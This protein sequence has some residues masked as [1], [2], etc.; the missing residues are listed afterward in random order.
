MS[1]ILAIP[2]VV[3]ALALVGCLGLLAA[4]VPYQF[5]L[6]IIVVAVTVTTAEV[7]WHAYRRSLWEGEPPALALVEGV[8]D[9]V[10]ASTDVVLLTSPSA[11]RTAVTYQAK[12]GAR[13]TTVALNKQFVA[14]LGAR[15]FRV[16]IAHEIGHVELGHLWLITAS[17]AVGH[18][19]AFAGIVAAVSMTDRVLG[20]FAA[21]AAYAAGRLFPAWIAW[22]CELEADRYAADRLGSDLVADFLLQLAM[23]LGAVHSRQINRRIDAVRAEARGPA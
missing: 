22:M 16:L 6:W 11:T 13:R 20:I 1:R 15:Q 9:L 14:S 7:L 3:L 8:A 4:V 17:S 10:P 18:F 23:Y 12:P 5:L 19:I 21:V 2:R